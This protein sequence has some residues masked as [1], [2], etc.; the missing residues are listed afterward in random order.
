MLLFYLI[1]RY[2]STKIV[3][4]TG[5]PMHSLTVSNT[6]KN[7]DFSTLSAALTA[8][9]CLEGPVTITLKAGV[10]HELVTINRPYTTIIGEGKDTVISMNRYAKEMLPDGLKRGTFRTQTV[11][12]DADFV[13]LKDLTI[14]NTAGPGRKFGQAIA[15][16]ADGDCLTFENVSLLGEQ[17]TLFTGPLP[18]KT[19]EPGGFRGPKEFAP[20]RVGR[21]LYKNCYIEGNVDFIFGGATCW[22]E[23]CELFTK[24]GSMPPDGEIYGYVTAASTPEESKYG[25]VFKDCRF[26]SDCPNASVYLG[27][28]WRDYAKTVLIDCELGPHIHPAGWHDWGKTAA[29]GKFFYAEYNTTP[30]PATRAPYSTILTKEEAAEYTRENV[31]GF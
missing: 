19:I 26:T 8:A 7:A 2:N 21:H 18:L 9:G 25:Y 4:Y 30:A 11:F 12:I 14:E 3:T 10:Y 28:P 29:H 5:G 6:D 16:Y 31:I 23:G 24:A 20:R 27:R 1:L 15:L 13:T 22:F 17:D